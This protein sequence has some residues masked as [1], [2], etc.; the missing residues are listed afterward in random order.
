MALTQTVDTQISQII[1][2]VSTN[3]LRQCVEQI[4]IPRHFKTQPKNNQKV[5]HWMKEQLQSY[6]YKTEFQGSF[7]NLISLPPS[8]PCILVG[9]HYDSVPM[10]MAVLVPPY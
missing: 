1:E 8:T 5:V 3:F 7:S 6:G 9:A 4:A 2:S 10:T